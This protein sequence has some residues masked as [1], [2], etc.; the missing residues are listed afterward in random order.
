MQPNKTKQNKEIYS[1]TSTYDRRVSHSFPAIGTLKL[2]IETNPVLKDILFSIIPSLLS[3]P[4]ASFR[5]V[6][7]CSP[8]KGR[9]RFGL[10]MS[11]SWHRCLQLVG[12][13]LI[14]GVRR[15]T[16]LGV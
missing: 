2:L 10:G 3:A 14:K 4:G 13:T 5:E 16:I 7:L 1:S 15:G 12:S 6:I 9:K 8:K 11:R